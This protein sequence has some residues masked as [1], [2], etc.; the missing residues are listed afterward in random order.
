TSFASRKSWARFEN[1]LSRIRKRRVSKTTNTRSSLETCWSCNADNP[2]CRFH[3]QAG[4]PALLPARREPVIQH[5]VNKDS[6]HGNVQPDRHG[7]AA[8]PAMTIPAPLK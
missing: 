7:P 5:H 8:E 3:V 6:G 1:T 2:V 4:L